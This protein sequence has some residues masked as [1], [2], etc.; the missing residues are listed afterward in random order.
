MISEYNTINR[1]IEK[2]KEHIQKAPLKGTR[3]M[4]D[5]RMNECSTN[6]KVMEEFTSNIFGEPKDKYLINE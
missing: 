5:W 3:L 4:K 1:S 2:W 6:R